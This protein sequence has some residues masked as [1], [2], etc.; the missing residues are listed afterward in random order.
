MKLRSKYLLLTG[1]GLVAIVFLV[2]TIMFNRAQPT[3]KEYA[4]ANAL[5]SE[6]RKV[7][8]FGADQKV[9]FEASRN[10]INLNAY[11]FLDQNAQDHLVTTLVNVQGVES[12]DGHIYLN[13][14]PVRSEVK[15]STPQGVTVSAIKQGTLLRTVRIK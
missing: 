2:G 6:I 11:G 1:L 15:S 8:Q 9:F 12:F 10:V 5:I 14:F 7:Q 3:E 4:V 13:F